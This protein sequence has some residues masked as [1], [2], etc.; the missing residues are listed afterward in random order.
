MSYKESDTTN[1][2]LN[3]E[4]DGRI[5]TSSAQQWASVAPAP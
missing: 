1:Y 5:Y 3:V 2:Y 4:I